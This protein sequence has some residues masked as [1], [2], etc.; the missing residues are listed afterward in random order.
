MTAL[1][2]DKEIGR[3]EQGPWQVYPVAASTTIYKGA[4]VAINSS[5]Y[6]VPA[7]DTAGLRLAG[8]AMEGKDN[9]SGSNGDL[10]CKC[11][12]TGVFPV[13]A[14]SITQAMVGRMLYIVDDQT[15][16]ETTT[17]WVPAGI[18]REYT[19]ATAGYIEI[20]KATG[21]RVDTIEL[22]QPL[23]AR[24]GSDWTESANG[25]ELTLNKTN[26][27]AYVSAAGLRVGDI[28]TAVQVAGGLG[29]TTGSAS[30]LVATLQSVTGAAGGSTVATIQLMDT[31]T[32]EADA[33]INATK[34]LA[35]AYTVL[36]DVA[37]QLKLDGTTANNA[38]CDLDVTAWSLTVQRSVYGG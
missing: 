5:G 23:A 6:L 26:G 19:S 22:M 13:V 34:T 16:D 28:I 36:T 10:E 7:S 9:S 32:G 38:A 37:V 31:V 21:Y 27:L 30:S 1:A 12:V 25:L 11:A 8:V 35:S 3:K 29:A 18:L 2:A 17:N 33:V 24:P 15:V 20:D 4:L 14:S